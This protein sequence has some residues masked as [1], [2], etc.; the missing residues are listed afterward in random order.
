MLWKRIISAVVGI[1]VLIFTV[2]YGGLLFLTL[3]SILAFLGL[4]EFYCLAANKGIVL[5][6]VLFITNG[7]I[8]IFLA[9]ANIHNGLIFDFFL[10]YVLITTLITQ[11]FRSEQGNA[12]LNTSLAFLGTIYVGWLSAHLVYLR[13]LPGG[14]F[15]VILVLLVTWANDTGAY[16]TGTNLGKRKLCPKISP[17][18]TIEGAIGGVL[19]S[20]IASFITGIWINHVLPGVKF[21]SLQLLVLGLIISFS[22]QFGD[23][24]ESL[25]KR[26]AG[27]K[28]SSNLIPGHG[29]IL[30]RFD[31]LLFA[32][33]VVYYYLRV[34]ILSIR[35]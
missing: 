16:F 17:N 14:F 13:S 35:W 9:L 10:F 18:K 8:F 6:K 34:F 21:S 24:V 4:H 19:C 23:L 27:V 30:D 15:Y 32:V 3:V 20:I 12:L 25:F 7:L 33:P 22:A 29:G 28:D 2:Y 5:P 31:S 1:P 11:L 26:D